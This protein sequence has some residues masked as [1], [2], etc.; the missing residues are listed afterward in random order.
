M[1]MV[2]GSY[3]DMDD[4]RMIREESE[5]SVHENLSDNVEIG[6]GYMDA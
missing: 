3:V 2:K 1:M 4:D 6:T 5:H